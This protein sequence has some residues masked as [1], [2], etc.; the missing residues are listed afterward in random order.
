MQDWVSWEKGNKK[1]DLCDWPSLVTGKDCQATGVNG[2]NA[3]EP[4]SLL[5]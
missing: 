2:E 4:R 5:I 3:K 1:D